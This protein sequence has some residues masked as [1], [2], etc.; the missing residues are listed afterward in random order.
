[1]GN[2]HFI[3]NQ[4]KKILGEGGGIKKGRRRG[5][6]EGGYRKYEWLFSF[7][8]WEV[9]GSKWGVK[10]QENNRQRITILRKRYFRF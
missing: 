7:R 8:E 6:G 1:M 2:Y 3:F 5:R 4:G 10:L 9:G